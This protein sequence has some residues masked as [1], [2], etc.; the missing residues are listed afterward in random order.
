MPASKLSVTDLQ[1]MHDQ[2]IAYFLDKW[3]TGSKNEGYL[4]ADNWGS[5]METKIRAQDRQPYSMT[6][7]ATKLGII[8]S[9]Q[10]QSRTQFLV[11]AKADQNDELK[12]VFATLALRDSER[13]SNFKY[14]E[15][16]VF[17][18]GLSVIYGAA[19]AYVDYSKLEPRVLFKRLTY[20]NVV[21]DINSTSY[22]PWDDGMFIAKIDRVYRFQLEAE[23]GKTEDLVDNNPANW[24]R[25]KQAYYV[26][27]AG[28]NSDYDII[29]KFT[30]YQKTIRTY[31]FALFPDSQNIFNLPSAVAGKYKTSK[32]AEARLR[33]LNA[34]YLSQ[35]FDIEGSVEQKD[36]QCVDK[37]V[38]ADSRL[39]EYEQTDLPTCPIKIFKC[40]HFED[41]FW[42][43]MD[44]LK[45]PQI[46]MDR[47]FSQ[48]DYTFGTDIKNVYQLN[49]QALAENETP[50]S[51]MRKAKTTGGV[52]QVGTNDL[53]IQS[54]PSKGINPQWVQVA[55]V[56]QQ[57]IEDFAGGRSFQGL[58]E[59]S[60][61]SGKAINLKKQ[62]GVLIAVLMFDNLSRWKKSLGEIA[63]Y[64]IQEYDSLQRQIKV[65][66]TEITPEMIQMLGQNYI[67]S[68]TD[69]QTGYVK[70]IP[71]L[72]DADLELIVTESA[73]TDSEKE[74]RLMSMIE[75]VSRVP[76]L[77][78]NP[79]FISKILEYDPMIK[80]QDRKAILQSMQAQLQAEA[81]QKQKEMNIKAAN[82]L[83]NGLSAEQALLVKQ[84]EGQKNAGRKA[85]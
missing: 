50:E 80:P 81:E 58:S 56:M 72:K 62:Q 71:A 17:D 67:P 63:L 2:G 54:I 25:D 61:E 31:Y 27:K 11:Q 76:L 13:N 69:P 53:A 41:D 74:A 47:L 7:A 16:E 10:K 18:S 32:E 34:V 60:G 21:W 24:G 12:G 75:L 37:Y 66:G 20:N 46:F 83:Q 84:N 45:S 39:L 6:V 42:S 40:F 38:F 79:V 85:S 55:T 64:L 48:I 78:N 33:E 77:Q 51:A 9:T 70:G 57:F 82:V 14:L 28:I 44:M 35:G 29:S 15:S 3:D 59:G 26:T 73:L 36:E 4:K 1:Y 49:V 52:I 68:Q 8:K 5:D 65:Q 23:Y 30:H 43:F 22:D 19:E